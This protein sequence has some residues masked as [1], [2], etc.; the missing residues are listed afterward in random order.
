MN[1]YGTHYTQSYS[2]SC[3]HDQLSHFIG[4][5]SLCGIRHRTN[6]Q[7]II[8]YQTR[9]FLFKILRIEPTFSWKRAPFLVLGKNRWRSN[10]PYSEVVFDIHDSN[11]EQSFFFQMSTFQKLN[12]KRYEL[13]LEPSSSVE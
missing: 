11:Y 4:Y 7:N 3:F 13:L 2:I 1:F 5:V 9:N 8:K 12:M 6:V 10:P